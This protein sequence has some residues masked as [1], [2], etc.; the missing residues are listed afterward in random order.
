MSFA[1]SVAPVLG[2]TMANVMFASGFPEVLAKRREGKL[3]D[4]NPLPTPIV[5]GNCLGWLSYALLSKDPYVTAANVPGLLLGFWYVLTC[6]PLASKPVA[7]QMEVTFL[8]LA[9]IHAATAVA[10]AFF[11][12]TRAGMASLYGI[13]SNLILLAYYGAPL[14]SIGKVLKDRSAASIYF[15][16]VAANGLNGAFWSVYALAIKDGW[17]RCWTTRCASKHFFSQAPPTNHEG[18][19]A[20]VRRASNQS[21]DACRSRVITC[22]VPLSHSRIRASTALG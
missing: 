11:V 1:T 19:S 15:P 21:S 7:K 2:A 9:A 13:V 16:T 17:P 14:S 6:L 3:G 4:Y 5:F 20:S 22:P 10:C 12:P 18:G 8:V